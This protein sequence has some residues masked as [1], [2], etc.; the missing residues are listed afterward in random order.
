MIIHLLSG[1][2]AT[3]TSEGLVRDEMP[4]AYEVRGSFYRLL[5]LIFTEDPAS[6]LH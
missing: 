3:P 6:H 4:G 1:G 5:V 2:K